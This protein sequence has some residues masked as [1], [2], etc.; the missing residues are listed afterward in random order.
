MNL[1]FEMN[2]EPLT[3]IP[4]PPALRWR[5]FRL[6]FMPVLLFAAALSCVCFIWERNISAPVFVGAVE[7]RSAEVMSP[8]AGK[9]QQLNVDHFQRV[10][11]GTPIA[12]LVP[13]DPRAALSVVQ[14]ELDVLRA[15]LD[16][17]LTSQRNARDYEDLRVGWLLQRV[18]L[19]TA[20][21]N[22]ELAHVEFQ[23]DAELHKQ[24][25]ISDQ[26]FDISQNAE[27]ALAVEVFERSNLVS[28]AGQGLKDLENMSVQQQTN[29]LT[30]SIATT[31]QA[32]E[33]KLKAAATGTEPITLIAPMDGV[34]SFIYHQAGENIPEGVPVLTIKGTEPERIVAYLRQPVP[35][36]PKI[37]E[38]VEVRTRTLQRQASLTRISSVGAQFEP[39]ANA[40]AIARPYGMVDLGLPLEIS[41][42]PGLK[43]RPGEIVDLS[44]VSE[45]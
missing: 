44:V 24:K 14:S 3:P 27:Q 36:E 8:Y 29:D 41:L 15:K 40:L 45:N 12:V 32:E 42:P 22:L 19:A 28:E 9:I 1:K 34:V 13:S 11:K 30:A 23:R 33:Q 39:I 20:R 21:V 31:L 35:F 5:E 10:T 6:R 17:Y 38:Q 4:T 37:G 2:R 26:A 7:G 16:P 25:L 18:D 43:V